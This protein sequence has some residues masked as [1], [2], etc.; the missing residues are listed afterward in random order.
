MAHSL[1]TGDKIVQGNTYTLPVAGTRKNN[2]TL[3]FVATFA[4]AP[5]PGDIYRSSEDND[6]IIKITSTRSSTFIAEVSTNVATNVA[7][8][9]SIYFDK[10]TGVG[11]DIISYASFNSLYS[12]QPNH[13]ID[14]NGAKVSLK[15]SSKS[16][17]SRLPDIEELFAYTTDTINN[18]W[19]EV[20]IESHQ[21]AAIAVGTVLYP[22]I[23]LD[24]ADGS[25]LEMPW[26]SF[27]PI[28]IY[29]GL[30]TGNEPTY[31]EP[32]IDGGNAFSY[33]FLPPIDGGNAYSPW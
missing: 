11:D 13:Q 18:Y 4:N 19:M 25:V 23:Q 32:I 7:A 22:S 27:N 33:Y 9:G 14:L 20:T 26:D 31:Q 17:W 5:M 29:P 24:L 15:L 16:Q 12:G 28:T 3:E 8:T 10:G 6:L 2:L 30:I 21:T 1:F